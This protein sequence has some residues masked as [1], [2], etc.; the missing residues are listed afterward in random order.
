MS[1]NQHHY[2]TDFTSVKI[3]HAPGGT[4][5]ISLGWSEEPA[6]PRPGKRPIAPPARPEPA[7]R[8]VREVREVREVSRPVAEE[9]KKSGDVHTS[10]RVRAPPGGKSSITF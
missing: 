10:V 6:A 8:D 9:S 4:S 2:G 1:E 3:H 5:S 7:T